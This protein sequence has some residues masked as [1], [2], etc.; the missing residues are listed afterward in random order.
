M[1][2]FN[3]RTQ[4]GG[5][6]PV[7]APFRRESAGLAP[8]RMDGPGP[9]A[10]PETQSEQLHFTVRYALPEYVSF[11]WQH[12]GYL[13]RR[14]RI[15]RMASWWLL[16]KSTSAAAMHFVTQ[17]R[18]R[19]LYEFTVDQHGIIRANGTG[20]TLVPWTDVSAIRRYT[21]GYMVILKRGTLPI[22]FRCLDLMQIAAMDA[23]AATLKA[24][25]K[26]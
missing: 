18:S 17:G 23:Y 10:G 9:G 21:R 16:S 1:S 2:W 20:V 25:R 13:I 8:A 19:H 15:G 14:R 26:V 3:H 7:G 6:A 12:G 4:Y 5:G 11:M 24:A 22:P